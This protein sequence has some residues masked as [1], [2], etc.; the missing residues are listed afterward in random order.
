MMCSHPS[1]CTATWFGQA[2]L[3]GRSYSFPWYR[4]RF[5]VVFLGHARLCLGLLPGL[6]FVF[7]DDRFLLGWVAVSA[8]K[9][10]NFSLKQ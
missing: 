8:E 5:P 4:L 10:T 9:N 7:V 2:D 3:G 6:Y 1:V